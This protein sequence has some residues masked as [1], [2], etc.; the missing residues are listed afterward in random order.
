VREC[1]S[2]AT[3]FFFK[4][5]VFPDLKITFLSTTSRR[6]FTEFLEVR[7][8]SKVLVLLPPYYSFVAKRSSSFLLRGLVSETFLVAFSVRPANSHLLG[9]GF[10][11]RT[12]PN[13]LAF[14]PF[15]PAGGPLFQNGVPWTGSLPL[16]PLQ[17]FSLFPFFKHENGLRRQA[18]IFFDRA[19]VE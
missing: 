2:F 7:E 14:F 10:F 16:S 3:H 5:R 12:A 11:R 6:A 8:T 4:K 17:A 18:R 13:V 19:E 1:A 9:L 15:S